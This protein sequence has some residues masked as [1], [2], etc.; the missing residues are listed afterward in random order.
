MVAG[1]TRFSAISRSASTV[2]LS[3]EDLLED[4]GCGNR[5]APLLARRLLVAN[6]GSDVHLEAADQSPLA[7]KGTEGL[8]VN[9][10][11]CCSPIPGDPIVGYVSSGR[12]LVIHTENCRN[13]EEFR[14]NPEKCVILSWDKD[15]D[16]EFTLDLK[17]YLEQRRGIVA[18]LAA[19]IT[20]AEANIEKISVEER[21][22][23]LSVTHLT[24]SV[25]GRKHLARVIRRLRTIRGVTKIVRSKNQQS[26]S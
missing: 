26:A 2:G 16:S 8:M 12:G 5:M 14:D 4:I 25:H 18:E 11:K 23:R 13:V 20:Q 6:K 24:L 22:A 17:L 21:D 9:F 1:V 15:I 10:A 3:F 7:I 19:A